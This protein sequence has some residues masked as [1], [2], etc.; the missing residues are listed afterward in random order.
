M[1]VFTIQIVETNGYN[2]YEEWWPTLKEIRYG[3]KQFVN[4]LTTYLSDGFWEVLESF[5]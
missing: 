4:D 2:P 3:N 1:T 5:L